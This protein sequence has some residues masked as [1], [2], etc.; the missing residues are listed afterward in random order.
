MEKP[1]MDER[2]EKVLVKLAELRE[3]IDQAESLVRNG[4]Y[5]PAKENPANPGVWMIGNFL[6]KDMRVSKAFN[7]RVAE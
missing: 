7:E 1:V 3:A 6:I 5:V 4:I 2:C